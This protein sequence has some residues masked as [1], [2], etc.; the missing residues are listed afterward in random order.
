[1]KI[2]IS[3]TMKGGEIDESYLKSINQKVTAE[4]V[5]I[6]IDK[7]HN[8]DLDPQ[9]RIEKEVK[10]SDILILIESNFVFKSD[11]VK[12]EI[13]I[14]REEGIPIYFTRQK[15]VIKTIKLMSSRLSVC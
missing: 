10:N 15:D 3:Y 14:A 6:F 7:L 8:N 2:F 11:W 13:Q 1:M 5:E 12:K 9:Q 4:N